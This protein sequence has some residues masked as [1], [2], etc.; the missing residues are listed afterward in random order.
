MTVRLIHL[1]DV[2]F[3]NLAI[4]TTFYCYDMHGQ[5]E[6]TEM[7][8]AVANGRRYTFAADE[9]VRSDQRAPYEFT[10]VCLAVGDKFK[11][12]DFVCELEKITNGE[13]MTAY[14]T[15]H[16]IASCAPVVLN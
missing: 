3:G 1:Q 16:A 13:A 14:G 12:T 6:K 2:L 11:H 7:G 15:R 10:F 5:H 9:V 4:G 8:A